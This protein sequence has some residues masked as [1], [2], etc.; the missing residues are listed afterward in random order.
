MVSDDPRIFKPE[1][2]QQQF[3]DGVNRGFINADG[4]R[5][6]LQSATPVGGG[7]G[8]GFTMVLLPF[9]TALLA[10]LVWVGGFAGFAPRFRA[11]LTALAP[12][13]WVVTSPGGTGNPLAVGIALGGLV[14]LVLTGLLLARRSVTRVWLGASGFLAFLVSL[15]VFAV[16]ALLVLVLILTPG[17]LLVGTSIATGADLDA[18]PLP[19][20]ATVRSWPLVLTALAVAWF[21]L[22]ATRRAARKR[23]AHRAALDRWPH[24]GGYP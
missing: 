8:F 1:V 21:A 23:S 22:G 13:A 4:S 17:L 24:P 18:V 5:A 15:G 19:D 20:G 9:I 14:L 11:I 12:E 2:E 3:L 16:S 6:G 7:V 10:A